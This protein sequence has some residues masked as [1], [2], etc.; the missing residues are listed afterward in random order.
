MI[1]LA[2]QSVSRF[3]SAYDRREQVMLAAGRLPIKTTAT[4]RLQSRAKPTN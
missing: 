4:V 2:A 3:T 1:L